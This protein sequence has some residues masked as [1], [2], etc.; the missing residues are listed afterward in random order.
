VAT[1]REE[2]FGPAITI[3]EADGEEEALR[4]ANDTEYGLS[5][6]VH[7]TDAERGARFARRLRAGMTHVND[8]P[9]NEEDNSAGVGF[10]RPFA[11]EPA[12]EVAAEIRLNCGALADLTARFLPGMRN[13]RHGVVISCGR[14]LCTALGQVWPD[15]Q[16]ALVNKAPGPYTNP[17]AGPHQVEA[18]CCASSRV[19]G[20]SM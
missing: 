19:I 6:A 11:D 12:D 8:S 3:I 10:H 15:P 1:A 14:R 13:A 7:T 20:A 17:G 9:V 16:N 2:V 18:T 5:S 4:L